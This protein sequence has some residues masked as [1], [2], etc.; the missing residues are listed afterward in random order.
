MAF[1]SDIIYVTW[2]QMVTWSSH[3]D[4]KTQQ[5]NNETMNTVF[6]QKRKCP[7]RSTAKAARPVLTFLVSCSVKSEK[8]HIGERS[9]GMVGSNKHRTFT[10]KAKSKNRVILTYWNLRTTMLTEIE[11]MAKVCC[12]CCW[13][14]ATGMLFRGWCT[15]VAAVLHLIFN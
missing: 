4:N 1:H 13:H 11:R 3:P 15:D 2:C 7:C 14:A 12:V 5:H 6:C 9:V 10:Q 8:I